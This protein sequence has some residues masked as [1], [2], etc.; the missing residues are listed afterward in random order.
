MVYWSRRQRFV[1]S[2][3][4]ISGAIKEEQIDGWSQEER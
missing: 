4:A 1:V 3:A 2:P